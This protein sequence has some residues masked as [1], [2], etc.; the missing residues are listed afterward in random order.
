MRNPRQIRQD[1]LD[2]WDK[3]ERGKIT[4]EEVH[5]I[6]DAANRELL[7]L[8]ALS[9]LGPSGPLAPRPSRS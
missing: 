7:S 5:Q 8:R 3:L 1:M 2:A 9:P 6:V 4:R